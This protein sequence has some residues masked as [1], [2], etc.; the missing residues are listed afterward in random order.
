MLI[1]FRFSK[2]DTVQN[3]D[4]VVNPGSVNVANQGDGLTLVNQTITE[5]PG[6]NPGPLAKGLTAAPGIGPASPNQPV[7][8]GPSTNSGPLVQA[9]S[10]APGLGTDKPDQPVTVTPAMTAQHTIEGGTYSPQSPNTENTTEN[11]VINQTYG[12]GTPKNVFV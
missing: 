7:G 1:S 3:P 11:T 5:G 4:N 2:E 12:Q 8:E 9:G 10:A 6:T